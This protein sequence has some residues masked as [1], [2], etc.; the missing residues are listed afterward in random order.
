[1]RTV[2]AASRTTSGGPTF[3]SKGSQKEK[4]N[5]KKLEVYLK[6]NERKIP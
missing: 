6:N 4:R 1:M 2:L 5:S 3:A